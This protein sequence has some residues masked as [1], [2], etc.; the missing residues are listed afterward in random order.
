MAEFRTLS[1]F[2]DDVI[3]DNLGRDPEHIFDAPN[4]TIKKESYT[5]PRGTVAARLTYFDETGKVVSVKNFINNKAVATIPPAI[6][7]ALEEVPVSKN[8]ASALSTLP[9]P[10]VKGDNYPNFNLS[11]V[12]DVGMKIVFDVAGIDDDRVQITFGGDYLNINIAAEPENPAPVEVFLVKAIDNP[13]QEYK[14]SIY[15]DTSKYSIKALKYSIQNGEV[16]IIIP[17][18]DKKENLMVFKPTGRTTQ[19]S[20]QRLV[21]KTSEK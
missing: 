2:F 16:Q 9:P 8:E 13:S 14:R 3:A 1:E 11:F 7:D 20:K 6:V 19:K 15:I 12:Q 18:N 4:L 10:L 17:N 21:E 5:D